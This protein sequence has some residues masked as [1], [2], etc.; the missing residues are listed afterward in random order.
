MRMSYD[1]SMHMMYDSDDYVVIGWSHKED[2][3]FGYELVDKGGDDQLPQQ[4]FLHG[5]AADAF[6]AQ[7]AAWDAKTPHCEQVEKTLDRYM[8]LGRTLLIYH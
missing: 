5:V 4:V 1:A 2:G 7:V 3:F 6:K 8:L